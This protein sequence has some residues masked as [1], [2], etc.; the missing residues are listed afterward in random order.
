MKNKSSKSR[1]QLLHQYYNYTGFYGFVWDAIKKTIPVIA[2]VILGVVI[3]NKF[4]NI[5]AG[6]V[7]LTEAL[8]PTGVL[9]FFFASETILGL[10]PP[11]IF[12][13]WAGKMNY[14][15]LFLGLLA[16][17]SY[18]GGLI[19]YAIGYSITK[20]PK[21]HSY[22]E[23]KLEKQLRQSR[24]WGGFLII[25]GALLPLP[26]SISCLTAGL[27]NFPF[28]SVTLYGSLRLLRFLLYGLVI[29]QVV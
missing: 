26:F 2:L 24:K 14:P 8:A 12:I 4:F 6:L 22:M 3:V 15:W 18:V 13:A 1:L 17:L 20:L 7:H 10:V 28:K 9:S 27:I 23:L 29:F 5:N 19:T 21:V 16:I 11:E 25:V